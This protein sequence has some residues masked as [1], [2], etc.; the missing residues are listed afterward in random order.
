MFILPKWITDIKKII[1]SESNNK[2]LGRIDNNWNFFPYISDSDISTYFSQMISGYVKMG[3]SSQL[4]NPSNSIQ[5]YIDNIPKMLNGE[6]IEF[7][8][9]DGIYDLNT[10]FSI[11][12]DNFING[13]II[14][15]ANNLN[16]VTF[17]FSNSGLLYFNNCNCNLQFS[18]I[19]FQYINPIENNELMLINLINGYNSSNVE[20]N[21]CSF[22]GDI[23]LDIN[24][25]IFNVKNC[26]IILN[27]CFNGDIYFPY[28]L[29]CNKQ[30]T[31]TL[32][33]SVIGNQLFLQKPT[34]IL[35][36]NGNQLIRDEITNE[37]FRIRVSNGLLEAVPLNIG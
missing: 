13:T 8:F 27:N 18:G 24:S 17:Q 21:S 25:A 36:E 10:I 31:V 3:S 9:E 7:N 19:N 12:F 22:I 37:L 34:L 32:N 11:S 4:L 14:L 33:N 1:S 28:G 23:N 35:D 30:T 16:N 15:S 26:N 6:I 2:I 20:F 5:E 29:T